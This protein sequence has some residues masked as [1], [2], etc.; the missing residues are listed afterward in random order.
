[1]KRK[2]LLLLFTV[3]LLALSSLNA[4]AQD[5][6]NPEDPGPMSDTPVDGGISLLLAA[7]AAYG[8]GRLRRRRRD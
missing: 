6:G 7:G 4:M 2:S 8:V 5:D 3:L 1:M